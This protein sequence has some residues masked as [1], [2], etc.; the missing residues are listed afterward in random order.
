[1]LTDAH[2]GVITF[3]KKFAHC[4]EGSCHQLKQRPN[5]DLKVP[6]TYLGS[7]SSNTK[8]SSKTC[9]VVVSSS[10]RSKTKILSGNDTCVL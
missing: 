5:A 3:K 1:M 8:V 4:V 2:L 10:V 9:Y 7:R 6:S